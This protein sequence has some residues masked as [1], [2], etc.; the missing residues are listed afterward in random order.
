MALSSQ[1]SSSVV[2]R[3]DSKGGEIVHQQLPTN[4]TARALAATGNPIIVRERNPADFTA[5]SGAGGSG[6][7]SDGGGDGGMSRA[8]VAAIAGPD[9]SATFWIPDSAKNEVGLLET[10]HRRGASNRTCVLLQSRPL[11]EL[12]CNFSTCAGMN[13]DLSH[14]AFRLPKAAMA[15]Q[16]MDA[17]LGPDDDDDDSNNTNGGGDCEEFVDDQTGQVFFQGG[18]GKF[19][20]I[21]QKRGYMR[22]TGPKRSGGTHSTPAAAGAGRISMSARGFKTAMRASLQS[23]QEED[24]Y[25][26]KYRDYSAWATGTYRSIAK[27]DTLFGRKYIEQC[28]AVHVGREPGEFVPITEAQFLFGIDMQQRQLMNQLSTVP[29]LNPSSGGG[30][31]SRASASSSSS[32]ASNA[33]S[34]HQYQVDINYSALNADQFRS[35]GAMLGD[36]LRPVG[37]E[38][39]EKKRAEREA[40]EKLHGTAPGGPNGGRYYDAP[41][42]YDW[43]PGAIRRRVRHQLETYYVSVGRLAVQVTVIGLV[44]YFGYQAVKPYISVFGGGGGGNNSSNKD[45]DDYDDRRGARRGNGSRERARSG[46]RRG[47]SS[48]GYDDDDDYGYVRRGLLR[49]IMMGPR[50]VMDYILAPADD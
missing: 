41:A 10:L 2:V 23:L 24:Y 42:W 15:L 36:G 11:P 9:I 30:G 34:Y 16:S 20:P 46:G 28:F 1:W 6:G 32:P 45:R 27:A 37:V 12:Q 35:L 13:I 7:T 22:R 44:S 39:E 18:D 38:F 8:L 43:S 3:A 26:V 40:H 31:G 48:R 4:G 47:G 5:A 49:T 14:N 21:E 17:Q 50:E 29:K 33:S 25:L 19:Y